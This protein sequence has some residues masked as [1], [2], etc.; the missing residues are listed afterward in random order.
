MEPIYVFSV[1]HFGKNDNIGMHFRKANVGDCG[2]HIPLYMHVLRVEDD[3]TLRLVAPTVLCD[4]L[5][6]VVMTTT[7]FVKELH[8]IH[9]NLITSLGQSK[10]SLKSPLV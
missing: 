8:I 1:S 2:T 9:L 4:V 10:F 3:F 6:V 7:Y 5:I